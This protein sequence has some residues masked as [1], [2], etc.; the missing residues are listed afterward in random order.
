MKIKTLTFAIGAV[1]GIMAG[2]ALVKHLAMPGMRKWRTRIESKQLD[3]EI[4][5]DILEYNHLHEDG[6]L[7]MS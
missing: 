2:A 4:R 7:R 5:L 1:S 3:T 6:N